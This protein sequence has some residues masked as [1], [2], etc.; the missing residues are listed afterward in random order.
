MGSSREARRAGHNPKKRPTAALNPK[1]SATAVGEIRVFHCMT[2]ESVIAAPTPSR[3]PNTPPQAEGQRF[4]QELHQDIHPGGAE[5]FTN[6]DL[7]GALGHRDQHDIHD[8]DAAHQEADRGN[9]GEQAGEY[10]SGLLLGRQHILL[11]AY[12]KIILSAGA[13]L[14]LPA[15]HPLQIDH[16]LFHRNTVLHLNRE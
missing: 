6:A 2:F 15:Q 4:D 16:P 3:I 13:N 7:T 12:G 10:L 8:P 9:A 1:A 11:I 14:V 5:S